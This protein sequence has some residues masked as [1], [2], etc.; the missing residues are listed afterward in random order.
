[1]SPVRACNH[2]G[3]P[4][5]TRHAPRRQATRSYSN[6]AAYRAM[7]VAVL[8][9]WGDLCWYCGEPVDRNDLELAH[10][11]AHAD[12][13]AFELDNLRASHG[14]RPG[15]VSCNRRAGRG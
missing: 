10:I 15:M 8:E 13:G 14:P 2:C 11:V 12:G 5:C 6:T 4:G 3:R 9:T 1:M 7:V